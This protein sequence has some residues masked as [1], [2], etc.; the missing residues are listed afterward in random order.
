MSSEH[1]RHG[2]AEKV[3]DIVVYAP[4]GAFDLLRHD[5]PRLAAEGRQRLEQRA[6]TARWIG[7]MAVTVGRQKV[8]Q[9]WSSFVAP[10]PARQDAPGA[11][12]PAGSAA[13]SA[14]QSVD[15]ATVEPPSEP[16]HGYDALPASELVHLLFR[17]TKAEL[18]LVRSYESATR[19]RRT[20]L[21]KVDQL[22]GAV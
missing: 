14:H 13:P 8:T 19:A 1:H 6:R 2:I 5:G 9:R 12:A 15:E 18:E 22:L 17:L 7:E 4:I 21:A 16:F 20:V 3:L 10:P 11:A